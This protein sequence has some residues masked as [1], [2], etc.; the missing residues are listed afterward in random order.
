M[1]APIKNVSLLVICVLLLPI[2]ALADFHFEAKKQDAVDAEDQ[3]LAAEITAFL[4]AYE[5]AYNNQDYRA[6]K[7]M[8]LDDGNPIYMAEEVPFPLYG[9]A[10]MDKYF[11]PAP[12]KRVLG[13][14]DNKYSEVRAKYLTPTISVATYRLDWDIKLTGMP[15]W[16]NPSPEDDAESWGLVHFVRHL[17]EITD[18]ELRIMERFNPISREELERQLEIE[19]FLAGETSD[20]PQ[21]E[22][23]EHHH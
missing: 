4:A 23:E 10:R 8:W 16:G 20:P 3:Q 13:G 22:D 5:K 18:D 17:G 15:A 6:L 7:S 11:D 14:I 2:S 21:T 12:G 19:R 9:K 1:F